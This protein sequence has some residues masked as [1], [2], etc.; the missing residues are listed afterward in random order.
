MELVT[1]YAPSSA[2]SLAVL[3]PNT[4]APWQSGPMPMEARA[5][6]LG[7]RSR[8][9][10]LAHRLRVYVYQAISVFDHMEFVIEKVQLLAA[11][12][13]DRL[14]AFQVQLYPSILASR[15]PLDQL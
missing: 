14:A 10:P 1:P 5:M 4:K 8:R 7:L 11:R 2:P 9:C 3:M 12:H 13:I 6:E 15:F